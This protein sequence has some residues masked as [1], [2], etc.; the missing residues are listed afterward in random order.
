M[1]VTTVLNTTTTTTANFESGNLDVSALQSIAIDFTVSTL[2]NPSSD[3]IEVQVSR[4]GA[5]GNPYQLLD[6]TITSTGSYSYDIGPGLP[7]NKFL[8]GTIQIALNNPF[9]L[10]LTTTI[11][12]IGK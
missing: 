10:N 1:A 2:T 4:V 12:V 5:D 11:S 9:G 7:I 3:F 6:T 8:G